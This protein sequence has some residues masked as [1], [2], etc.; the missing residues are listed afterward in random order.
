MKYSL[1]ERRFACPPIAPQQRM[2]RRQALQELAG[3]PIQFLNLPINPDQV[4]KVDEIGV[5]DGNQTLTPPPKGDMSIEWFGRIFD[6][7][8]AGCQEPFHF[9]EQLFYAGNN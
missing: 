2:V 3:I 7:S 1:D 5:F 6:C 4:H 8:G 9:V